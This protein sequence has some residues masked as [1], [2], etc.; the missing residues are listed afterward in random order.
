MKY[1]QLVMELVLGV[2]DAG[3]DGGLERTRSVNL[4]SRFEGRRA[5]SRSGPPCSVT[6]NLGW[7]HGLRCSVLLLVAFQGLKNK[8]MGPATIGR[9]TVGKTSVGLWTGR[10]GN[11]EMR[12]KPTDA[13]S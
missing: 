5:K 12:P 2:G 8:T 4:M 9:P 10:V 11:L 13:S 3:N 7:V 6:F 1:G